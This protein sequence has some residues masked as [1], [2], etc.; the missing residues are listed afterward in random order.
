MTIYLAIKFH[1]DFSN[2]AFIESVAGAIEKAGHKTIVAVRDFEEWGTKKFTNQQIMMQDFQAIR[3][4]DMLVVEFSEKGVGLGIATGYAKALGKPVLVIAKTGSDIS[5]TIEGSADR[6][7]FYDASDEL[8]AM[9]KS[10]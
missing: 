8:V 9:F 5:Q 1:E 3:E 4:A 2:R 10:F 6:V 7:I